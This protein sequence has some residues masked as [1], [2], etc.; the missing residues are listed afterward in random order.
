MAQNVILERTA[1][2]KTK[3]RQFSYFFAK[4]FGRANHTQQSAIDQTD[5][6]GKTAL[7]R[8]AECGHIDIVK[9]HVANGAN[10]DQIDPN[11]TALMSAV[12][13]NHIEMVRLLLA[14]GADVNR[15]ETFHIT[16]LHHA[17]AK[18]EN[19]IVEMLLKAGANINAQTRHI[20]VSRLMRKDN[21]DVYNNTPLMN[22]AQCGH[23][24]T[25][26]LLLDCG[27]K[28]NFK[29]N[30]NNPYS[31]L[32]YAAQ[33]DHAEIVKL[34][35]D[36]G[37]EI[38]L[39]SNP[40]NP[41]SALMYAAK[42][43]HTETV[44]ILLEKGADPFQKDKFGNTALM[45]AA[46]Q[47]HTET[48]RALTAKE[49]NVDQH[50]H[51]G[52]TALT[53]AAKKGH[54]EAVKMLIKKGANVHE[55]TLS[56]RCPLSVSAKSAKTEV[57]AYLLTLETIANHPDTGFL[58]AENRNATLRKAAEE[59]HLDLV[60]QLLRFPDVLASVTVYDNA[61]LRAAQNNG[62]D[63]V[64]ARLMQIEAVRQFELSNHGADSLRGFAQDTENA[65]RP[66][67]PKQKGMLG[68]VRWRYK[69]RYEQEGLEVILQD[70]KQYLEAQ[71]ANSPAR[72]Q[73]GRALPLAHKASL[74]SQKPYYE[75]IY[76]T[77]WRY[78][79]QKPNPWMSEKALWVAREHHI[80]SANISKQDIENLAY[81][82]CAASDESMAPSKGYSHESIKEGFAREV[83]LMG[84]RH[85]WDKKREVTK[86]IE[87]EHRVIVEEYDDME[88]DKP[89]CSMGVTQGLV[90]SVVGK[91]LFNAPEER[92]LNPFILKRTVTEHLI[93]ENKQYKDNIAVRLS[94]LTLD[95]TEQLQEALVE[96]VSGSEL[97]AEQRKAL[98]VFN[99]SQQSIS[100]FMEYCKMYFGASRVTNTTELIKWQDENYEGYSAIIQHLC[101]NMTDSFADEINS[102][103][104]GQIREKSRAK[105]NALMFSDQRE[106]TSTTKKIPVVASALAVGVVNQ[107]EEFTNIGRSVVSA[108]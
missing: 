59:G 23:T 51:L 48:I 1:V 32:M 108:A 18:G 106:T 107:A 20:D 105:R 90:Q 75:N 33:H 14:L 6:D 54:I 26:K 81:F 8:A 50:N 36:R 84:R 62:H 60:N 38:D 27:A 17:A 12:S 67:A 35:L 16:A 70:F 99:I 49:T 76:H 92:E 102:I 87:G 69:A 83:A 96:K 30:P 79:F 100:S 97:S 72:D 86:I 29:G 56:G 93:S 40:S 82:W 63:A 4:L 37:A 80:G 104:T 41:Y 101:S 55:R 66:L 21:S 65:M 44:R 9:A 64:V 47:G 95:E 2:R 46:G 45:I 25:V 39:K 42:H 68:A 94:A 73:K 88:G 11:G 91:P 5:E 78:L 43:G 10:I 98:D 58:L 77:A 89:S 13:M 31:A 34:L 103:L 15:V 24:E 28:V 7:M 61:A 85:N 52:E 74:V 71:Y 3:R 19:A 57:I 22:A 53:I